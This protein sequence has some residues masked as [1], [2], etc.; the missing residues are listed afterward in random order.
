MPATGAKRRQ[1]NQRGYAGEI[2]HREGEVVML[3]GCRGSHQV[4][5][6]GP[7]MVSPNVLTLSTPSALSIVT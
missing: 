3:H 7:L 4:S 5:E 1:S 2:A 6:S